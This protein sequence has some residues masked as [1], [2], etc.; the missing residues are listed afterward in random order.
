MRLKPGLATKWS[1]DPNDHK[2]WVFELRPGVKFHDGC[3]WNAD[4][5]LWNFDRL[6]SDK[7]AAFS[8]AHF[9]RGTVAHQRYRPCRKNR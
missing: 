9:A 4:V 1:V 3:D 8:P 6:M 5:A 7:S 2:K